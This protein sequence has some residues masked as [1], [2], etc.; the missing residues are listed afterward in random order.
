MSAATGQVVLFRGCDRSGQKTKALTAPANT[1][2]AY[3]WFEECDQF[4]G[5]AEVRTIQQSATRGAAEG[6]PFF[7]FYSFNP[8]RNRGSWVNEIIAERIS[9][10]APVYKANYTDVPREWLP[11]QTFQDAEALKETDEESYRHEWL[12][13]PVGFGNEVFERVEVRRPTAEEWSSCSMWS[14][15]VDWGFSKD[16]WCWVR[17]GYIPTTRTLLIVDEMHGQGISN[18]ESAEMVASR[19]AHALSRDGEVVAPAEAFAPVLC[20]AAEPKSIADYQAAGIS[21]KGAPKQGAYNVRN[22]TKWL[23]QRASIV[24]DPACPLAAKEFPAYAYALTPQ[25]EA[26]GLLPDA[27]NHAIDAVRYDASIFIADRRFI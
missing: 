22:S 3:Q 23:Q 12:G 5:M 14:Y 26:T 2:F 6:A 4:C 1:Y 25:G 17:V 24:I 10:G 15:G 19:M 20:D 9:K 7:R 27:D 13:E 18:A 11:E 8:P 21:A 16:P